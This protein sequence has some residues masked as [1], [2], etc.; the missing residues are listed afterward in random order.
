MKP[1]EARESAAESRF[2]QR[3]LKGKDISR[4]AYE[5]CNIKDR[6]ELLEEATRLLKKT[7]AEEA[8]ILGS[9]KC[10]LDIPSADCDWASATAED[11]VKI[12]RQHTC[13]V[14]SASGPLTFD[15]TF[16]GTMRLP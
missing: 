6:K 10:Q 12:S 11:R 15:L 2:Q 8:E 14:H 1:R 16:R 3:L 7:Q 9:I 4:A 13:G 5:L